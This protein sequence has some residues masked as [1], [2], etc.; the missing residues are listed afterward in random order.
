MYTKGMVKNNSYVY[1]NHLLAF[2]TSKPT[3]DPSGLVIPSGIHSPL[4]ASVWAHEL[5]SHPDK[6]YVDY[7]L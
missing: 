2:D 4:S 3:R 1:L 5:P 7:I 6:A